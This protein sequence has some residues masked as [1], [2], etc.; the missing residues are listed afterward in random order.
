MTQT[1][2]ERETAPVLAAGPKASVRRESKLVGWAKKNLAFLLFV[3]LPTLITTVYMGAIAS[4]QFVTEARFV[5]RSAA[6]SSGNSS[7]SL[8]GALIGGGGGGMSTMSASESY[9]VADYLD[10]HDAVMALQKDLNLVQLYRR[11]EADLLARLWWSD[12]PAER[13]FDYYERMVSVKI[14]P[15]SG[16]V[17]LRAYAFRPDDAHKIAERL[18]ELAEDRVNTFSKRAEADT[19]GVA[20]AEVA[21]AEKRVLNSQT[22]ITE[23]RLNEQSL[24]PVKSATALMT[25][26]GGLEAQLAQARAQQSAQGKFLNPDSPQQQAL[27]GKISALQAQIDRET[28]RMAGGDKGVLAPI[29]AKYETL[30]LSKDFAEKQYAAALASL[31]SARLE[32]M[33]QHMFVVRIVEPNQPDMSTYPRRFVDVLSIFITLLVS[34]GIGW[35]IYA[36]MKEHAA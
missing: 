8:L 4:D 11:P 19:L 15:S 12:P 24:D 25:V 30:E 31:E 7:A 23:Y 28:A 27:S 36:G 1:H 20:K 22:E 16:I 29:V 32:A 34:Y 13:L 21:E 33:K 10:S 18:L 2:F 3:I 5:V 26:V 35:L 14:D 9:S 17:I 6:Q